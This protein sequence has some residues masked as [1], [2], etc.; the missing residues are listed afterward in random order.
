MLPQPGRRAKKPA[1]RPPAQT[2]KLNSR[3]VMNFL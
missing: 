2:S 3:I 1:M